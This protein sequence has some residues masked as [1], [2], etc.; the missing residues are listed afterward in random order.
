LRETCALAGKPTRHSDESSHVT[1]R[2]RRAEGM[3]LFISF[4]ECW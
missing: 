1:T 2:V 4:D 3:I